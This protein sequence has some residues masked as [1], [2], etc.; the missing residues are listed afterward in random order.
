MLHR[1]RNMIVKNQRSRCVGIYFVL[2]YLLTE[3]MFLPVFFFFFL[4]KT[5]TQCNHS[6][7]TPQQQNL[8][9]CWRFFI[10]AQNDLSSGWCLLLARCHRSPGAF[11]LHVRALRLGI[12]TKL[13]RGILYYIEF[14]TPR[15]PG[16]HC[17]GKVSGRSFFLL[18]IVVKWRECREKNRNHSL[19][20]YRQ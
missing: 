18:F 2:L 1:Y 15:V 20:K 3:N 4:P 11:L 13:S 6:N 9:G 5:M 8:S 16:H 10:R 19:K 14:F 12:L 17:G 7:S